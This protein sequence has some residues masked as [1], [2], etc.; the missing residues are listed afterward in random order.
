MIKVVENVSI[1]EPMLYQKVYASLDDKNKQ[2]LDA[3]IVRGG[4]NF[5]ELRE[6]AGIIIQ[7]VGEI[8]V[9]AGKVA[10]NATTAVVNFKSGN[11]V[12]GALDMQKTVEAFLAAGGDIKEILD[13]CQNAA[14]KIHDTNV[15]PVVLKVEYTEKPAITSNAAIAPAS[16]LLNTPSPLRRSSQDL[17]VGKLLQTTA[18]EEKDTK[19]TSLS[20]KAAAK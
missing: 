13:A 20:P 2:L 11:A 8:T 19:N 4:K 16:P 5:E 18:I 7:N 14:K 1:V 10:T 12:Q 6:A 9:N 17:H 3:A 15:E